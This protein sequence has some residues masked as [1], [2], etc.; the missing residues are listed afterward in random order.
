VR[1]RFWAS[2]PATYDLRFDGIVSQALLAT[3]CIFLAVYVLYSFR[4]VKVTSRFA[5][6]S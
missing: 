3:L 2:P 4:I 5:T 6:G 1:A